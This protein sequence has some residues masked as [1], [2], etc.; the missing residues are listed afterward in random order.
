MDVGPQD[1]AG[2]SAGLSQAAVNLTASKEA[3]K[4]AEL[5]AQL[6]ANR[7]A[8]LKQEEDKA[9][10][11][12]A[13]TQTRTQAIVTLRVENESKFQAKEQ[14]YKEKWTSIRNAQAQNSDERT[15]ARA[16]REASGQALLGAKMA[17]HASTKQQSQQM[18][19]AKKD[20][21]EGDRMA[22]ADRSNFIKA[23]KQEAKRA[24]EMD[25]LATLEK[26]RADYDQRTA[27][28]EMLKVRTD[29]LVA[30][31]EREEMELIQRL[32]NTQTVQRNAYEELEAALGTTSQQ[33]SSGAK[34]SGKGQ[35]QMRP[36]A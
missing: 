1:P 21:E 18:L 24:C 12:I 31:M 11:K 5:D 14:Y 29:A 26:Y 9:W 10:K 13:E 2:A 16:R 6:L 23:R 17:N 20:R 4:R 33:I 28:E 15:Q 7:I 32:Q 30:K 19:M 36:A 35:G 3:R 22:N 27:Q 8:L 25:R 34:G